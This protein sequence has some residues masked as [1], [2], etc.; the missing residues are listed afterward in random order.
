M[1]AVRTL[2]TSDISSSSAGCASCLLL[3]RMPGP[4][5][6]PRGWWASSPHSPCCPQGQWSFSKGPS[7]ALSWARHFRPADGVLRSP[8]R[9]LLGESFHPGINM[10]GDPCQDLSGPR[11]VTRRPPGVQGRRLSWKR[12]EHRGRGSVHC[13]PPRLAVT[14]ARPRVPEFRQLCVGAP[15]PAPRSWAA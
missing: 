4:P 2:P 12:A 10:P 15:A 1:P 14:G 9:A 3:V 7:G 5:T 13:G 6:G 8:G 11:G